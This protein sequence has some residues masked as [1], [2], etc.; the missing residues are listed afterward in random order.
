[1][2]RVGLDAAAT[3][4]RTAALLR[5]TSVAHRRYAHINAGHVPDIIRGFSAGG[6]PHTYIAEF[7]CCS[8]Y[9]KQGGGP[10]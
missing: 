6:P 1:M 5:N 8:P 9:L 4:Q 10:R 3:P 2:L 7:K